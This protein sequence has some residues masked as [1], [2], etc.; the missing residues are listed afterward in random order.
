MGKV[1]REDVDKAKAEWKAAVVKAIGAGWEFAADEAASEAW[2][3][4]MELK[5]EYEDESN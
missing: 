3:K 4:Y 2:F 1:T 5:R